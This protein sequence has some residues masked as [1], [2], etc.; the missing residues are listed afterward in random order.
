MCVLRPGDGHYSVLMVHRG[1]APF[2]PE[3]WVF[4]GGKLEEAD[5]GAA[6]ATVVPGGAAPEV[7]ASVRCAIR[8]TYEE[9]G[10]L[11]GADLDVAS[12]LE[13]ET[14]TSPG[15]FWDQLHGEGIVLDT[16]EVAYL[17]NWVTP[18]VSPLRF[19]TRFFVALVAAGTQARHHPAE[20]LDAMWM[21]PE[22]ALTRYQEG[23]WPMILP[24]VKHLELLASWEDATA[25]VDYAK[26]SE[27]VAVHPHPV[28]DGDVWR[29]ILPGEPG[30]EAAG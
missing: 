29:F 27:V 26:R 7:L 6:A 14:D 5:Q 25:L 30:Y 8:E 12:R 10:V 9:A 21:T 28:R 24:T 11:V 3:M 22:N 20:M 17:S 16:E 4:P 18:A 15:R 23:E 2:A 13:M 19:D 1:A